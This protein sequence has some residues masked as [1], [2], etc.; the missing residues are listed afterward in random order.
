MLQERNHTIMHLG[1]HLG[2]GVHSLLPLL[3][4]GEKPLLFNVNKLPP[5]KDPYL[6]QPFGI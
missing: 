5:G 1:A 3:R 4:G 2:I 6:L